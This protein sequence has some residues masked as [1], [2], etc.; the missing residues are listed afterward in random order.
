LSPN[1]KVDRNAL[2]EPDSTNTLRDNAVVA[3]T[4]EVEA[5]VADILRQLL[6]IEQLN[7]DDNFFVLGGHSLL[8][9]QLIVRVREAFGVELA[10]RDVFEAPTVAGISAAIERRV[11]ASLE[12]MTEEQANS[13]LKSMQ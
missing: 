5:V 1:G 10:L 2:P 3:P 12:S 7:I 11:A 13:L 4:T 6:R 9:T 8:G